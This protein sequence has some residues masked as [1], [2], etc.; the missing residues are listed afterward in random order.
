MRRICAIPIRRWK[1]GALST[2]TLALLAIS[3]VAA[4]RTQDPGG[5]P[6]QQNKSCWDGTTLYG[7]YAKVDAKDCDNTAVCIKYSCTGSVDCTKQG[8]EGCTY[9]VRGKLTKYNPDTKKYDI[10]IAD[11]NL[12]SDVVTCNSTK[13]DVAGQFFNAQPSGTMLQIEFFI[14]KTRCNPPGETKKRVFNFLTVP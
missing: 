2:S 12:G 7:N 14:H 1:W 9:C 8:T 10:D 3:A 11:E 5:D 4:T 13:S 6:E